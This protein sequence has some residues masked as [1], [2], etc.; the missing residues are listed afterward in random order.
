MSQIT[1]EGNKGRYFSIFIAILNLNLIPGNIAS[2]YLLKKNT[3]LPLPLG[4]SSSSNATT[5][6]T[7]APDPLVDMVVGW[8]SKNS[9][10]FIVLSIA[11]TVG[12]L[13]LLFFKPVMTLN[14]L[15]IPPLSILP[16]V[17]SQE[18]K[19]GGALSGAGG[20]T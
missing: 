6:T 16:S 7:T 12:I 20:I 13:G 9:V 1:T 14:S 19:I 2:H 3:T 17:F 11:C 8:D 18:K 10:L 4:Y 15:Y 5:T